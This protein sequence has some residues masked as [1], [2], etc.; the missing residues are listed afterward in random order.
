MPI[1]NPIEKASAIGWAIHMMRLRVREKSHLQD[2]NS[3]I[4]LGIAQ[5]I[6][7]LRE[8]RR[9]LIDEWVKI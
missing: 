8:L 5:D 3:N 6:R 2:R 1:K 9:E 7:N 4:R